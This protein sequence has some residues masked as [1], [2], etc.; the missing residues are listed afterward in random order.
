M[1]F[2]LALTCLT[3]S[4][5]TMATSM[6]VT[7]IEPVFIFSSNLKGAQIKVSNISA[8]AS[9]NTSYKH[10][11][12]EDGIRYVTSYLENSKT[13]KTSNIPAEGIELNSLDQKEIKLVIE[14]G[15]KLES[16]AK[17]NFKNKNCTLNISG[18]VQVIEVASG[19]RI[20]NEHFNLNYLSSFE[21]NS[22]ASA[23][24]QK[25]ARVFSF[26]V[27]EDGTTRG[28]GAKLCGLKLTLVS[29]QSLKLPFFYNEEMCALK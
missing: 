26:E 25:K 8:F 13:V 3:F 12:N 27:L 17:R 23:A 19:K 22:D 24:L 16:P 21:D 7:P 20:G 10:W 28:N 1:K 6:F 18:S 5:I 2:V 9:C 11:V 29:G 15:L 4:Q 14:E